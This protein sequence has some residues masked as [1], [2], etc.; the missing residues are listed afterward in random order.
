MKLFD[1]QKQNFDLPDAIISYFPNFLQKDT[2]DIY[3]RVFLEELH[4]EQKDIKIFGR[5]IPQPRLTSLYAV[6]EIPYSYSNLTLYPKNFTPELIEILEKLKSETEGNFT[7][8]LAN[9][10]RDGNDSMGWHSDD[11]KELGKNPVIASLSL[12]GERSFHLKHKSKNSKL[13]LDLKHGSL[14]I[15]AGPTQH[16]WKHQLPKTRKKVSPR[17][18]LTFRRIL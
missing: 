3:F 9:L 10:Y 1:N 7:H 8:C 13:S 11:E 4:W 14:L 12:G 5:T 17:I 18:N 16:F 6:N 15:M 2:A